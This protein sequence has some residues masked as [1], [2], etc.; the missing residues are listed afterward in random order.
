MLFSVQFNVLFSVQYKV[1]L[2]F[3]SMGEIIKCDHSANETYC[4]VLYFLWYCTLIFVAM[5]FTTGEL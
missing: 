2:T 3:E 4:A 5:L 1:V